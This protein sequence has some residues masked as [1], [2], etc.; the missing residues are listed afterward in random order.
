MESELIDLIIKLLFFVVVAAI[1]IF[2]F[3]ARIKQW[4]LHLFNIF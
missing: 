2:L 4:V 3:G 1:I